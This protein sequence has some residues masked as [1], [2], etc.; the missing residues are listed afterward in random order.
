MD[1]IAENALKTTVHIIDRDVKPYCS[2]YWP[3]KKAT[4][5]WSSLGHEAI[6]SQNCKCDHEDNSLFSKGFIHQIHISSL[7]KACVGHCLMLC[8]VQVDDISQSS[9]NHQHHKHIIEGH[10]ICLSVFSQKNTSV[11]PCVTPPRFSFRKKAL[12]CQWEKTPLVSPAWSVLRSQGV[13]LMGYLSASQHQ[14]RYRDTTF[15]NQ[16][17]WPNRKK[18]IHLQKL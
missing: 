16:S 9:L 3:L 14:C 2:P 1:K 6:A 7:A 11:I 4:C 15:D 18:E 8:S 5:H 12:G 17:W 13:R 10:Q